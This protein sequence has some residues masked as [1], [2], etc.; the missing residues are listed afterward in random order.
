MKKVL[1]LTHFFA[2]CNLAATQRSSAWA[3]HLHK[4]GWYPIFVTRHWK[5]NKKEGNKYQFEA[6]NEPLSIEKNKHFTVYKLPYTP[7][8]KDK[9]FVRFRETKLNI[10]YLGIRFLYSFLEKINRHFT[11][12]NSTYEQALKLIEK[13]N[14]IVAILVTVAPFELMK[15]GF[16]LHQKT[17]LPWFI[18]YQDDW[19]TNE[20][21]WGDTFFH[22]LMRRNEAFFE[23]K[24]LKTSR[25]FFSVTPDYVQRIGRLS[26]QTEG[27]VN[28][29]GYQLGE[30]SP[31]P[32]PLQN[33]LIDDQ[34]L[35]NKIQI[36]YLGTL[37]PQQN[38]EWVLETF[39]I[40]LQQLKK[41]PKRR[42]CFIFLGINIDEVQ[43][44]RVIEAS[45]G[46]EQ[47]IQTLARI[48]QSEALSIMD[49]ADI[50]LLPAYGD[51][52]GIIPCKVFEYM[53]AEK[54][55]LHA[56]A[57]KNIITQLLTK[58]GLGVCINAQ[59]ELIHFFNDCLE[60]NF[61]KMIPE[62]A[63]DREYINQF[64]ESEQSKRL[65]QFIDRKITENEY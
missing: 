52:Q 11:S 50:L 58:A 62:T 5:T 4:N 27:A 9:C 14:E 35:A 41:E 3:T 23:R 65:A 33:T 18:D 8:L 43:Q 19:T 25:G 38:I 29:I 12:Q 60:G 17:R 20:L 53:N 37:Y 22:R 55:V 1:I 26:P 21:R 56:P 30:K 63:I 45:Q 34:S 64:S 54:K 36:L 28:Y 31:Q 51:L 47:Y 39:K 6:I 57:D 40:A 44:K 32:I 61:Q 13:D 46:I 49:T 15:I 42:V 2:P 24:W 16:D 48:P 59:N 10:L 7:N